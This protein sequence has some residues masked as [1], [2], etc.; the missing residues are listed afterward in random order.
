MKPAAFEYHAPDTLDEVLA[1]LAEHGADAKVL[2]GGQ[3]LI[4]TMN[5]R[6]AQP[7][8]LVDLNG[9]A[10]LSGVEESGT[11][12]VSIGTMTRQRTAERSELVRDL[13]PLLHETMPHIAHPQIR[14]RGTVGGSVAHADPA[15]ELPAVTLALE[16]TLHLQ[17]GAGR[18]TLPARDFFTGL[19]ETALEPDEVLVS[20][21]IPTQ[22]PR[23][24][25]QRR[26][27]TGP[28][29]VGRGHSGGTGARRPSHSC[30]RSRRRH[31]RHRPARRHP[32]LGGLPAA[33]DLG[34]GPTGADG[35]VRTGR[36]RTGVIRRSGVG[37]RW[38]SVGLMP[39]REGAPSCDGLGD[40][41]SVRP[42]V[43]AE[44]S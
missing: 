7:A 10:G 5:F 17:G 9:V 20:I 30:R 31:G 26:R 8:V 3:S 25:P 32:R 27:R 38:V 14:N 13:C 43:S 24:A 23:G 40:C 36:R 21:E 4:P 12:L 2:A 15:A 39:D 28:G 33:P 34:T 19:F 16:A 1:L 6:L 37:S 18:R 44:T 22:P 11:G 29:G 41:G 35:R 42:R